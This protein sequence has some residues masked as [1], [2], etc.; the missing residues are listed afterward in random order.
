M[1]WV[2]RMLRLPL[3]ALLLALGLLGLLLVQP[4]LPMQ[5]RRGLVRAWSRLLMLLC[6]VRVREAWMGDPVAPRRLAEL[7]RG[8]LL[9]ANHVSWLDVFAIDSLAASAFVAKAEIRRWPVIGW[10]VSLAGT[11]YISRGSRSAMPEVLA[12]MRQHLQR[13]YPV[14]LFPEGTTHAGLPLKPFHGSLL[15]AAI[16][17]EADIVPIGLLYRHSDGTPG[18]GA[19]YLD[20]TSF[21][22]SLWTVLGA[23][24]LEVRVLVLAPVGSAGSDRRELAG[25]VREMVEMM[26]VKVS[27]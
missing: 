1:P 5:G 12:Q 26:L 27:K 13:G 14:A 18:V 25:G 19:Y 23:S 7:V 21:M 16:D 24:A 8:R 11:I 10:L 2:R 6:G 22:Q 20:E 15:Q 17:E 4:W 9:V 3:L